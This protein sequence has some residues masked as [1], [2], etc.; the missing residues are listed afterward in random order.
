LNGKESWTEIEKNPIS[1]N[2]KE[3]PIVEMTPLLNRVQKSLEGTADTFFERRGVT[4]RDRVPVSGVTIYIYEK[5]S[6]LGVHDDLIIPDK[7]V[8]VFTSLLYL[9]DDFTGG[10][11]F[12]PNT[13]EKIVPEENMGLV[14]HN[15]LCMPHTLFPVES[16]TRLTVNL[17]CMVRF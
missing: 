14:F 2:V 12:F 16:G 3:L 5:G 8:N 1:I 13:G 7:G 4:W 17:D 10:D 9:N 15:N 11:L 6:G